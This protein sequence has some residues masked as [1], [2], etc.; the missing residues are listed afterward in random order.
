MRA[1]FDGTGR[2]GIMMSIFVV[3]IDR[4]VCKEK[5]GWKGYGCVSFIWGFIDIFIGG[6][7]WF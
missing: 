1:S 7:G 5:K 4:M 3:I 6:G 2:C